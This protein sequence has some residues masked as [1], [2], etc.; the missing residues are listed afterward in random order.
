MTTLA[1]EFDVIIIGGGPAGLSAALLLGRSRR[2]VLLFDNNKPRNAAATAVHGFLTRDGIAPQELRRIA[3]DQLRSYPNVRLDENDVTD[4]RKLDAGFEVL[5]AQD[6]HPCRRLLI[7]TG[8]LDEMPAITG[9]ADFYGKGIFHCPYCDAWEYSDKRLGVFAFGSSA[10][11]LALELTCW[12][13]TI[14]VFTDGQALSDNTREDLRRFGITLH[15]Q[16]I[17]RVEGNGT[18]EVVVLS[19]G[20]RVP[21]DAL[22]FNTDRV[23][24]SFFAR[25][26]GCAMNE[27]DTV[28]TGN[29][30]TTNVPELFVAGDASRSVQFAIVAA[31]EGAEAAFAINQSLLKE[32][33]ER[34]RRKS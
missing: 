22:F 9:F 27:G 30:E 8:V 24:R 21:C 4:V 23:Q 15:E 10:A 33:L 5:V 26:L 25:K 2:S 6:T 3:R 13:K 29:F 11:G 19:D 34:A 31:G 14:S 7:A 18:L 28:S 32:D 20:T 17:A 1:S 16:A 12:S